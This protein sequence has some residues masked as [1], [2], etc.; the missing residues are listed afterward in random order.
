ME[1]VVHVGEGMRLL[2]SEVIVSEPPWGGPTVPGWLSKRLGSGHRVLL[3]GARGSGA[4][5]Q[6]WRPAQSLAR[7]EGI[8]LFFS[9]TCCTLSKT[10]YGELRQRLPVGAPVLEAVREGKT[11]GESCQCHAP[12]A[13]AR[14]GALQ[15]PAAS[16]CVAL[17]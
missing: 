11:A 15:Q 5:C 2:I 13:V 3:A 4:C 16:A 8:Y 9:K 12:V 14:C 7:S 6:C 10:N 17:P 1:P